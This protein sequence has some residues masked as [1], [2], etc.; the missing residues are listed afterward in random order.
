MIRTNWGRH[1]LGSHGRE[2]A[3]K[4]SELIGVQLGHYESVG[5]PFSPDSPMIPVQFI[6]EINPILD[7]VFEKQGW[8]LQSGLARNRPEKRQSNFRS[9]FDSWEHAGPLTDW[10]QAKRELLREAKKR[11]LL[12]R[13][14]RWANSHRIRH[15]TEQQVIELAAS[16]HMGIADLMAYQ[17]NERQQKRSSRDTEMVALPGQGIRMLDQLPAPVAQV[18]QKINELFDALGEEF[19]DPEAAVL[20]H[21]TAAR[22]LIWAGKRQLYKGPF[23]WPWLPLRPLDVSPFVP[24]ISRALCQVHLLRKHFGSLAPA[25]ARDKKRSRENSAGIAALALL[26]FG[27]IDEPALLN[28]LIKGDV[29]ILPVPA[30]PNAIAVHCRSLNYTCG[31]GGLAALA[32]LS[33]YRRR[34][35]SNSEPNLESAL[36]KILPENSTTKRTKAV[37][38]LCSTVSITN[39]IERSGA[40]NLALDFEDGCTCFDESQLAWLL[41]ET[42]ENRTEDLESDPVS[43]LGADNSV[44]NQT[45]GSFDIREEYR[46]LLQMRRVNRD[47][48]L[49]LSGET[50]RYDY[51]E[52]TSER[53]KIIKEA[54]LRTQSKN[55]SWF[56]RL[57]A[58]WFETE[59]SRPQHT[60]S[61]KLMAYSSVFGSYSEVATRMK[62]ILLQRT[63]TQISNVPTTEVLEEI[64]ELILENAPESTVQRMCQTVLSFHSNAVRELG[65]DDL[66]PSNYWAYWRPRRGERATVKSSIPST[67]EL[68]AINKLLARSA[69]PDVEYGEFEDIDKRVIRCAYF[70][71]NLARASGARIGEITGM[72]A[73]D[74]LLP[75]KQSG[76]IIRQN[77]WRPLKTRAARRAVDI[78]S[79]IPSAI[80]SLLSR[81]ISAEL[82]SSTPRLRNQAW[83]FADLSSRPLP[84]YEHRKLV[85]QAAKALG[86]GLFR[87]HRLRH[88]WANEALLQLLNGLKLDDL[89]AR[90][91]QISTKLLWPRDGAM[92]RSQIGH[93]RLRMTLICYFHMPWLFQLQYQA[94]DPSRTCEN[95]AACLGITRSGGYR[96]LTEANNDADAIVAREIARLFP[97]SEETE[98]HDDG[99]PH[100]YLHV[101]QK[102]PRLCVGLHALGQGVTTETVNMRPGITSREMET[103]RSIDVELAR[104]TSIGIMRDNPYAALR[105]SRPPRWRDGAER[106]QS[107]WERLE[108]RNDQEIRY[109]ARI[110][111]QYASR[112]L[113]HDLR[114]KREPRSQM[115]LPTTAAER[116]RQELR[117]LDIKLNVEMN[118]DSLVLVSARTSGKVNIT[119]ELVWTLAICWIVGQL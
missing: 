30:I 61:S 16:I 95:V 60:N 104:A 20:A 4:N 116:I 78:S 98:S 26:L 6:K 21:N 83:L 71:F 64:Y 117:S 115:I 108:M 102:D 2:F 82:G 76:L 65:I 25:N 22:A 34:G 69:D 31:L 87:W 10:N 88:R 96:R 62:N 24:G 86:Q 18:D 99:I 72:R 1:Y 32:Y 111:Q 42:S 90:Q 5:Y 15:E 33:W 105:H 41:G 53:R 52:K 14:E 113:Q 55:W 85:N 59:L 97:T 58:G 19:T 39:R 45:P 28:E 12:I 107:F 81:H 75:A 94:A 49:A 79:Q 89:S 47:V 67:D 110:W 106:L 54:Q 3:E 118:S 29:R 27:G 66:D 9:H 17:I 92:I 84:S 37:K 7:K 114:C 103:M 80:R 48:E 101:N 109:I 13:R 112:G 70:S 119:S 91:P 40:A 43:S 57:W 11:N 77:R 44:G 8:T 93:S 46:T 56:G 68:E 36:S 23:Y 38:A 74:M 51:A 63:P 35:E 100:V 50:W 73:N